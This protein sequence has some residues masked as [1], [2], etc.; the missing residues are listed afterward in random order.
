[1]TAGDVVLIR[2]PQTGGGTSKLRPAL[3]LAQLPGPY[4]SLLI[5]GISTQLQLL[6]PDWDEIFDSRQ[7]DFAATGLAR[8]SAARLSYLYAADAGEVVGP[9]GRVAE[10]R[11]LAIRTRLANAIRS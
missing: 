11:L 6:V 7:A 10:P 2:L 9:P 8:T 3:I 4:Q 1:M 5:C